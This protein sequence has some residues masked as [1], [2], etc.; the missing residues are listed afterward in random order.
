MRDKTMSF[1]NNYHNQLCGNIKLLDELIVYQD[2]WFV[3]KTA[4]ILALKSR[5]IS[6]CQNLIAIVLY[7]ITNSN[8][9]DIYICIYTY[10]FI[11]VQTFILTTF[12]YIIV[13]KLFI[14]LSNRIDLQGK[15]ARFLGESFD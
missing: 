10:Y 9:V 1:F 14:M 8:R 13:F 5:Y 3:C 4:T 2:S 12:F 15:R 11:F 6:N 7:F